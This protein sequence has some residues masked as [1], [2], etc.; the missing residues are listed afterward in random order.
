MLDLI[1]V[2]ALLLTAGLLS[3]MPARANEPDALINGLVLLDALESENWFD[4]DT[5]G[6][7]FVDAES[8]KLFSLR[9]KVLNKRLRDRDEDRWGL[10]VQ[11]KLRLTRQEFRTIDEVDLDLENFKTIGIEP[12]FLFDFPINETWS[13]VPNVEVGYTREFEENRDIF[14][15]AGAL[16]L[17][18]ENDYGSI[19]PRF[20]PQVRYGAKYD[21]DLSLTED[22]LEASAEVGAYFPALDVKMRNDRVL[23]T[24]FHLKATRYIKNIEFIEAGRPVGIDVSFEAGMRIGFDPRYRIWKIK[25]PAGLKLSYL[26]GPDFRGFKLSFGG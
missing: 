15:A 16:A 5:G 1:R 21:N 26:F 9:F 8:Q 17:H 24:R 2:P 20:V 6:G 4:T 25:I 11:A 14:A 13:F 3:V 18:W 19:V 22:F 10:K 7:E 12:K 23:R